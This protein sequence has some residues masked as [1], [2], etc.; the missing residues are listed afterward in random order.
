MKV[1]VIAA[2]GKAGQLITKEAVDRGHDVTAIVRGK[3]KSASSK[4]IEGK[5]ILSLVKADLAGFDVV[6]D[7]FG[8]WTPE[9]L[10]DHVKTSQHLADLLSGTDTRL[11]IVGGAGSLYVDPEHSVQLVDTPDFPAEFVPLA[12]AQRDELTEI[13]KRDDVRWTFVSPAADFVAD[14]SRTGEYIL[15]GEELT[16]NAAGASSISYADYAIAMVDEAERTGSDA[17]V[18]ERIS[19]LGK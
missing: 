5:D 15:A 4:A 8:A 19:V 13:R 16:T 18:A 10:G 2:N 7:A 6:I 11:L 17:H 12:S 14:G 1:A 3:N 9:T